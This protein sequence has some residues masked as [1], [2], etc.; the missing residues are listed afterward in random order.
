MG[1]VATWRG[2]SLRG[3]SS[4]QSRLVGDQLW[5]QRR[6][7]DFSVEDLS[8]RL[9][10]QVAYS[11]DPGEVF[12]ELCRASAGGV[13]DYAGFSYRRLDDDEALY[14]PCPSPDHPG[15]PRGFLDPFA[16][17]PRRAVLHPVDHTPPADVLEDSGV[18]PAREAIAG[19]GAPEPEARQAAS[20]PSRRAPD[21]SWF[22]HPGVAAVKQ[23][24]GLPL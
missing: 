14:W 16:T 12:A 20:V 6:G 9:D 17:P 2:G 11:T 21:P 5:R 22:E 19:I 1:S 15:T 18:V 7:R 8:A 24:R 4:D 23:S 13:V 3:L 10:A